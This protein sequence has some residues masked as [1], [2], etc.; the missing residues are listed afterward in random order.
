MKKYCNM[1][2]IER[3]SAEM[4]ATVKRNKKSP[5][6]WAVILAALL[7]PTMAMAQ[8]NVPEKVDDG[9]TEYVK[10]VAVSA[11]KTYPEGNQ[12]TY[13]E[14]TG[15]PTEKEL[16]DKMEKYLT[17]IMRVSRM[18]VYF[19]QDIF[20]L[21]ADADV[22]PEW[23]VDEMNVFLRDYYAEIEKEKE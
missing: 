17:Q 19:N 2:T 5:I 8:S 13:V 20:L 14:A 7:L 9:K 15:L 3:K 21:D 16:A 22:N 4:S 1:K 11:T 6:R 12:I 23:V 18:K 10:F